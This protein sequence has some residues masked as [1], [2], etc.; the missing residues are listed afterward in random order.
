METPTALAAVEGGK[1]TVWA[2]TQ[3]PFG[4]QEQIARSLG[5]RLEDVRVIV[6]FVGGGFGGKSASSQAVEAARLA[7]RTDGFSG[8]DLKGMVDVA[9]E[10]LTSLL[11]PLIIVV[12]GAAVAF[13]AMSILF[14][15]IQ[16]SEFVD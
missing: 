10:G 14:P 15:L 4:T 1:I 3:S 9:V 12:M 16:M 5:Y 11:E 13:I 7:R 8:A 2:S 6:P